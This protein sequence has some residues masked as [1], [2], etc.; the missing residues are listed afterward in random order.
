M[1]V[2]GVCLDVDEFRA[3]MGEVM[4][5]SRDTSDFLLHTTEEY[6]FENRSQFIYFFFLTFQDNG[7]Q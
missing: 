7:L 5:F 4:H 2:I 3:L 1:P 6:A